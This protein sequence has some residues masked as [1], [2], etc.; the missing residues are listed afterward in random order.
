MPAQTDSAVHPTKPTA[1]ALAKNATPLGTS[2]GEK[3]SAV[4]AQ[5]IVAETSAQLVT[6]I[7]AGT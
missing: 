7:N 3:K 5:Q 4:K 2:A 1:I 6:T